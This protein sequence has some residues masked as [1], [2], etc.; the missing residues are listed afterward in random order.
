MKKFVIHFLSVLALTFLVSNVNALPPPIDLGIQN[1]PQQ[2]PVWCWAAVAQQIIFALR[3][4]SGTPDQCG[5]VA[6]ASRVPPAA[7]CQSP[8]SCMRTG[9]LVE[10]QGLIL[11]F[12]GHYS[13]ITPPASPM[14]VYQTLASGRAIIMAVQ[15]SPYSGHVVV[16]RGMA[17]VPAPMGVQPVLYINDP[18]GYFTQPVPFMNILPYWRAAIVVY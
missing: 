15:S 14:A 4:A 7:C 11:H 17:W 12:G 8:A 9:Q 18:M 10:I 2:T 3:G 16:I 6:I 13:A 1:I 5:L